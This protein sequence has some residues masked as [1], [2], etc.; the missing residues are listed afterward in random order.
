MATVNIFNVNKMIVLGVRN[1]T[2]V[3]LSYD[4]N[5]KG[6]A[7]PFIYENKDFSNHALGLSIMALTINQ[8]VEIKEKSATIIAPTDV[9]IR[10]LQ[11]RKILNQNNDID[12]DSLIETIADQWTNMPDDENLFESLK[13]V[14][15]AYINMVNNGFS[16]NFVKRHTLDRW[17][18][19]RNAC[20]ENGIQD[21]DILLFKDGVD[22]KCGSNSLD[23][24]YLNGEFKVS[25]Q[26]TVSNDRIFKNYYIP[27]K[28]LNVYLMRA[29]KMNKI[30]EEMLPSIELEDISVGK[31]SKE[32]LA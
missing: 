16:Y 8:L 19:N 32:L 11:I 15:E 4:I 22:T 21:G 5:K 1:N 30:L 31:E 29:R 9:V 6:D 28:G 12:I 20:E 7:V 23:T 17:Q 25:V 13:D 3:R 18:L 26:E 10:M 2:I 24:S 27:R 14:C